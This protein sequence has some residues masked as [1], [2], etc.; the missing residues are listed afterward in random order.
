MARRTAGKIVTTFSALSEL[1]S[2]W[3]TSVFPE[4]VRAH[5]FG[6]K[7]KADGPDIHISLYGG[8]SE[9]GVRI[10]EDM[11]NQY[12]CEEGSANGM[13]LP[14]VATYDIL[15]LLLQELKVIGFA[16]RIV[17]CDHDENAAVS[18][19][20]ETYMNTD[21]IEDIC[22]KSRSIS[23]LTLRLHR[24]SAMLMALGKDDNYTTVFNRI[25]DAE[26]KFYA[27]RKES[28][29]DYFPRIGGM[30]TD[31][32]TDSLLEATWHILDMY[33]TTLATMSTSIFPRMVERAFEELAEEIAA[34]RAY[35]PLHSIISAIA[36]Y[37][38]KEHGMDMNPSFGRDELMTSLSVFYADTEKRRDIVRLLVDRCVLTV[39]YK[40]DENGVEENEPPKDADA[41]MFDESVNAVFTLPRAAFAY[42]LTYQRF[43]HIVHHGDENNFST[44]IT[45][46]QEHPTDKRL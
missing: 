21:S 39:A 3:T 31:T 1:V 4:N 16:Q 40:R 35:P 9:Q 12:A 46:E 5:D 2:E 44:N 18:L 17:S 45:I 26:E 10:Y 33:M 41:M 38:Q 8:L 42:L 22:E 36:A 43:E 24:F 15:T 30:G 14:P 34:G 13:I 37:L 23:E 27:N 29:K 11:L 32:A 28:L 6:A 7:V 19:M 20:L 25:A